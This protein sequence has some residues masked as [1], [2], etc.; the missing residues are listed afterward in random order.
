MIKEKII[1]Q[2]PKPVEEPIVEQ[3]IQ[4]GNLLSLKLSKKK[5]KVKEP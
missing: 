4:E 1:A 2:K 3:T 5:S